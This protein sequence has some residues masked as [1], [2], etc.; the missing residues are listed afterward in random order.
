MKYPL[1]LCVCL[2]VPEVFHT[3]SSEH[4]ICDG[5]QL[6]MAKSVEIKIYVEMLAMPDCLTVSFV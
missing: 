5:V 4:A 1:C 2:S 6:K 3:Y